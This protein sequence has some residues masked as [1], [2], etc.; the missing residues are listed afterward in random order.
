M[1]QQTGMEVFVINAIN[2]ESI[3]NIRYPLLYISNGRPLSMKIFERVSS[4]CLLAYSLCQK[5]N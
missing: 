1:Q 2:A 5:A 4:Q 3:V